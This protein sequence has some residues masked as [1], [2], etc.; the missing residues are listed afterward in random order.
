MERCSV[1]DRPAT[2]TEG[3][4]LRR[5]LSDALGIDGLSL[6]RYRVPGGERLSL[7]R[8]AHTAQ[9][10]VFVV[11]AGEATFETRAGE[12]TVGEREAIRFGPG[13]FQCGRNDADE[14]LAVLAVG[15]PRDAGETLISWTPELGD[16]ACPDCGYDAMRVEATDGGAV[17]VCPECDTGWDP[18]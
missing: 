8:H 17:L 13:E 3:G 9:E 15:A 1:D 10:E 12:V 11:L 2:V 5:S 7:S 4:A 14:D 18:D 6:N 16:V